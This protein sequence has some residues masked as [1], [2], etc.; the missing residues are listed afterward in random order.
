MIFCSESCII[1]GLRNQHGVE[2]KIQTSLN[3]LEL[4]FHQLLA[5]W[6]MMK[7]TYSYL[8][9]VV[10][11]LKEGRNLEAPDKNGM[12]KRRTY[13][14]SDYRTVYYLCTN[15]ELLPIDRFSDISLR[16][17]VLTK[18]LV[19]SEQFFVKA[20]VPFKPSKE[21]LIMTGTLLC[22]HIMNCSISYLS[23]REY[24]VSTVFF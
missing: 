24:Q 22:H 14:P 19:A 9:E 10:P 15:L 13:D 6:V 8:K 2:C 11:H 4:P 5:F 17:F 16:A 1:E 21:D 20:G 23:I 3:A 7:S 12:N 18:L